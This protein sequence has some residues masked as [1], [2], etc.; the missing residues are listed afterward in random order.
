MLNIVIP[1]EN[2]DDGEG[3][4]LTVNSST[5]RLSKH[6]EA[7]RSQSVMNRRLSAGPLIGTA[8][9]AYAAVP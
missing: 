3:S 2:R 7:N 4:Y 8:C 5:R 6:A 9:S 1:I